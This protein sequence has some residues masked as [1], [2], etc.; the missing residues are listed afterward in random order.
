MGFV[1]SNIGICSLSRLLVWSLDGVAKWYGVRSEV[2]ST[3]LLMT[4][5][6]RSAVLPGMSSGQGKARSQ[7][8]S[9]ASEVL[10]SP[11]ETCHFSLLAREAVSFIIMTGCRR[12]SF[13]HIIVDGLDESDV[14]RRSLAWLSRKSVRTVSN[15]IGGRYI[16]FHPLFRRRDCEYQF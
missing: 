9:G 11:S 12:G 1:P 14:Q 4:T 15:K 7:L 6:G 10:P 5:D 8:I 13:R 16:S 2:V 3:V